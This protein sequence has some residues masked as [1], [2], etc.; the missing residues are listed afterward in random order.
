MQHFLAHG[1]AA[2]AILGLFHLV[3]LVRD[4]FDFSGLIAR[5]FSTVESWATWA[6][7]AVATLSVIAEGLVLVRALIRR[8]K[9]SQNEG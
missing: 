9:E 6:V 8:R 7:V 4:H 3:K 2:A 1:I 5:Y